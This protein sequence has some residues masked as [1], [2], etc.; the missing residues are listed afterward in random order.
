[1]SPKAK[2]LIYIA[3][4][5]MRIINIMLNSIIR[6]SD[7][8]GFSHYSRPRCHPSQTLRDLSADIGSTHG[9]R[10]QP[11]ALFKVDL[12]NSYS[13]LVS[14]LDASHSL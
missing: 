6:F 7:I 14:H 8:G 1:M 5:I 12:S 13:L 11:P 2:F 4:S 9:I 10:H 3:D